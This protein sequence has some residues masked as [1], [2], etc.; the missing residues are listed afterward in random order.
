MRTTGRSRR[1]VD[2]RNI[3]FFPPDDDGSILALSATA[4][5]SG[6]LS[7]GGADAYQK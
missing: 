1:P 2:L 6:R 4:T 3:Y 7:E 5:H